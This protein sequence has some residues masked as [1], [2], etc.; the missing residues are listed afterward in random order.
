MTIIKS[1]LCKSC[2]GLLDIDIDR[3]V[4]ICPFC[5]ITYD[6][7][8]FRE[9]NVLDIANRALNRNEFGSAKEAFEF[10]LQKDPHNFE[11]LRGILLCNCKWQTMAPFL[12]SDKVFLKENDATLLMAIENSTAE[13]KEYFTSIRNALSRLYEYRRN[14]AE[15]TRLTEIRDVDRARLNSLYMS[16]RL[17]EERFTE[18]AR[19][20]F[21]E[22]ADY[23]MIGLLFSVAVAIVVGIVASAIY[24][25]LWVPVAILVMVLV[26]VA[27]YN[28]AKAITSNTLDGAIAP[29]KEKVDKIDK[30]CEEKRQYGDG[31]LKEYKEMAK[32][33]IA[34][35][36]KM[37]KTPGGNKETGEEATYDEDDL[38]LEL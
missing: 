27:I 4:Y 6:Y 32:K 23:D 18:S 37:H 10:I 22:F 35:D 21:A 31:V 28:I 14:S 15:I 8:Y 30:E 34:A 3:Q 13:S 12:N 29:V 1:H 9:E 36:M 5:G 2:G 19:K 26:V 33:I 25:S 16:K 24:I 17:N 20:F 11:A 7:E 38:G